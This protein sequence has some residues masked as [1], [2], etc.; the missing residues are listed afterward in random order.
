M[1]AH[2]CTASRARAHWR[3]ARL[4][5]GHHGAG[6]GRHGQNVRERGR[7][8]PQQRVL[9]AF[10]LGLIHVE[11]V[12]CTQSSWHSPGEAV[13]GSTPGDPGRASSAGKH[14]C[15]ARCHTQARAPGHGEKRAETHTTTYQEGHPAPT[16]R[17]SCPPFARPLP[18]LSATTPLTLLRPRAPAGCCRCHRRRPARPRHPEPAGRGPQTQRAPPRPSRARSRAPPAAARVPAPAPC[19]ACLQKMAPRT[20]GGGPVA[21]A[22]DTQEEEGAEG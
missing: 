17:P 8:M 4:P 14:T 13:T 1:D 12:S 19:A 11:G 10:E 16:P 20:N 6:N 2:A 22:S 15:P 21:A 9:P 3:R 7:V 18:L 5:I